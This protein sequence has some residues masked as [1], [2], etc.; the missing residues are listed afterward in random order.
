MKS[1]GGP[2]RTPPV[3]IFSTTISRRATKLG[4][5]MQV[6][7]ISTPAKF[8]GPSPIIN[9]FTSHMCSIQGH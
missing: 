4:T 5:H 3:G 6:P 8:Q 9:F 7:S 1:Q 2:N